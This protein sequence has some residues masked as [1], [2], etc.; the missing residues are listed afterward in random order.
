MESREVERQGGW[1]GRGDVEMRGSC[2]E[3]RRTGCVIVGIGV[4]IMG[5]E[6][7][8]RCVEVVNG[9]YGSRPVKGPRGML[10]VLRMSVAP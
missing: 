1:K 3:L 8:Q 4:V 7:R 6:T 5:V 10:T 2:R 9:E